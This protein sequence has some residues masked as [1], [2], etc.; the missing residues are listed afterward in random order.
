MARTVNLSRKIEKRLPPELVSLI[1]MSATIAAGRNQALY[2]VGG[3][4][5][6]L[7]LGKPNFDLDFAVEGDA[8]SLAKEL[9]AQTSGKLITHRRFNTAK[10][11]L[12]RWSLDFAT[13]RAETYERPGA[14]PEVKPGSLEDDLFRRDFTVNA[15]AVRLFPEPYGRLI[16]LYGGFADLRNGLIRVLHEKSFIDDSTRIWRAMRYEQRLDFQIEPVTLRLLK[17]DVPMLDTISGDRIRHELE[18]VLAEDLP[19]KI[20]H[21]ASVL[22]ALSR[23]HPALKG[24]AWLKDKYGRARIMAQ[25]P[26]RNAVYWALLTYRLDRQELER[27]IA[28]LHL[29]RKLAVILRVTNRSKTGLKLLSRKSASRSEIYS[30]MHGYSYAALLTHLVASDSVRA[31]NAIDLYLE[32]LR[33]IR[34][35]LTGADLQKMGMPAG[36]QIQEALVTLRKARLD[37]KITSREEEEKRVRLLLKRAQIQAGK[38]ASR[39][40]S[41]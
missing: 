41:R 6:D 40:R 8:I 37:G 38:Q 21:R 18:L 35:A 15:M 23:A 16:D 17:R 9:A 39:T 33:F 25:D 27:V 29:E 31:R 20:L 30:L 12:A 19:E 10:L 36:R 22:K 24:D 5:R 4:V 7:L 32:K 11:K 28:F 1:R 2:L 14:L 3:V 13:A 34:P 26:A